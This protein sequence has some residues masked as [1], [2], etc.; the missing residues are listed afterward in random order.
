MPFSHSRGTGRGGFTLNGFTPP[1]ASA[2]TG[3]FTLN[4]FT[5][6][7]VHCEGFISPVDAFRHGRSRK[8]F[9]MRRYEKCARKSLG[10]RTYKN[11]GLK[12]SWN[13]H[14]Q[15]NPGGPP[16]F[17]SSDSSRFCLLL[18]PTR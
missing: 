18:S 12:P 5:L 13:E 14:L 10:I 7:K 3:G 4:G 17:A 9:R 6:N 11:K 8:P 16:S 15:K 1:V 2:G